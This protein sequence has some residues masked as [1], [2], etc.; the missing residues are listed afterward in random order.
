M[1]QFP[2]N[3]G[4]REVWLILLGTP[5]ISSTSRVSII[6]FFE[7]DFLV[8][9]TGSGLCQFD[10]IDRNCVT[11]YQVEDTGNSSLIAPSRPACPK[12]AIEE[13][14]FFNVRQLLYSDYMMHQSVWLKVKKSKVLKRKESKESFSFY[15]EASDSQK[16][17]P[18][19][20]FLKFIDPDSE[21]LRAGR[22][23]DTPYNEN[24]MGTSLK[25][26]S[27]MKAIHH[28]AKGCT[29]S[30]V[31]RRNNIVQKRL[32]LQ[33]TI[34]CT[35]N[36]SCATWTGGSYKWVSANKIF[37]PNSSR[38][39]LVPDVLYSMACY[40]TPTTKAHAEQFLSCMLLTPP[41]RP[42]L[43][44]LVKSFVGPYILK[45]KEEIINT[46]IKELKELNDGIIINMDVGYTGARKAQCATVMVGSGSR[47]I[48]SRTDTENGAWLKEGILISTALEEA[49]TIHK[50]DVVAVEIDDNA[51][52]K[53]K[54]EN[55]KRVNGPIEFTIFF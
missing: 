1:V 47:A 43:N 20:S 8:S 36:K 14:V 23:P 53:K 55:Y 39:A 33:V 54:I 40:M 44:D 34:N 19:S 24:F 31:I 17:T 28:H 16:S 37:Y 6:H 32:S 21:N 42:M 3:E 2:S 26:V 13:S 50:L 45:E 48:F 27:L 38:P 11:K 49:I 30:I 22:V 46:R 15:A 52:N 9:S 18:S 29:G 41:S 35:K 12:S 4:E 10:T 25:L 51:A 7:V 5:T